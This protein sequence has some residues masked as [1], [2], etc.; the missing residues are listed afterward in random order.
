MTV[1]DHRNRDNNQIGKRPPLIYTHP[2][3]EERFSTW[4][5][6]HSPEARKKELAKAQ[7]ILA[8]EEKDVTQKAQIAA[9]KAEEKDF[10]EGLNK[11]DRAIYKEFVAGGKRKITQASKSKKKRLGTRS[12]RRNKR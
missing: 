6:D 2:K 5:K 10:S 7:T 12:C 4:K 8:Q 3:E 1:P 9:R 11:E